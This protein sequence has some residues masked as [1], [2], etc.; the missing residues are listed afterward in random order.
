MS[1]QQTNTYKYNT[2]SQNEKKHDKIVFLY[3]NDF[4][5]LC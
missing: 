4:V 1:E 3:I 2:E 5:Y